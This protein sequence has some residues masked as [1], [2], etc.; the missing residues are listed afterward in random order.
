MRCKAC[1]EGWPSVFAGFDDDFVRAFAAV[2]EAASEDVRR[3]PLLA[4]RR[5]DF[6][7]FLPG[8]RALLTLL[9]VLAVFLA[10][11]A[12]VLLDDRAVLADCVLM[13]PI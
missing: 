4:A 13:S 11:R 3:V 12:G 9:A 10:V 2:L 8:D 6:S 1:A 7:D 5:A